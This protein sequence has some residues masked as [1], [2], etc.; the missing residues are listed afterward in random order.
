MAKA[1][2]FLYIG[3]INKQWAVAFPSATDIK[4]VNDLPSYLE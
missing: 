1:H 4:K 2:F 3:F